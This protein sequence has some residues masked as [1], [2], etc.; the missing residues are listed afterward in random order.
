MAVVVDST[1]HFGQWRWIV[2][3]AP[4]EEVSALPLVPTNDA[5]SSTSQGGGGGSW[6]AAGRAAAI[7]TAARSASARMS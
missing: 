6:P 1:C 4:V 5:P 2:R 7:D 3:F